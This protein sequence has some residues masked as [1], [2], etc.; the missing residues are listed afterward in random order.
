MQPTGAT[1]TYVATRIGDPLFALTA[2]VDHRPAHVHSVFRS[3]INLTSA[4]EL[5][6][7]VR[8]EAGGLPNGILVADLPESWTDGVRVGMEVVL[9]GA[10]AQI[11]DAGLVIRLE[12][13]RRWSARIPCADGRRWPARS[14]VVHALARRQVRATGERTAAGPAAMAG[15]MTIPAARERLAAVS[16]AIDGADR[17][18]AAAAA[19]SLI[20]L[21][22]GL[23][24]SGDDAIAGIEAALHALG[25][26]AAGFLATA[27]D[28]VVARTT[29]V[30]AALL[31]HAARGEFSERIHRLIAAL[32]GEDTAAIP[33]AIERAVAWGATSGADCLIGVLAGLD[34]ATAT[35]A[36]DAA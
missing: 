29:D 11:S 10:T 21:G 33:L 32:L 28:D 13:A 19:R 2:G 23:T 15:L 35:S 8:A 36:R 9:N 34:A 24:P 16:R 26:P 12:A 7:I 30:S 20:G 1:R 22:P 6:P 18:G 25:H 31:R 3:A 14:S 27:L 5:V 17:R 4:G